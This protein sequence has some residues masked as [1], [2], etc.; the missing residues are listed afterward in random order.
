VS[1]LR[2]QSFL[3][4]KMAKKERELMNMINQRLREA[5]LHLR[6]KVVKIHSDG[7]ISTEYAPPIYKW[8][9]EDVQ[10]TT[11]VLEELTKFQ[12]K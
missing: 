11:I 5:N 3:N 2:K 8:I 12:L 6:L 4:E 10:A 7:S 9:E 1:S